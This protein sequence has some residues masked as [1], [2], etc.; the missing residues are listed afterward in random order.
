MLAELDKDGLPLSEAE[1]DAAHAKNFIFAGVMG[2]KHGVADA[3]CEPGPDAMRVMMCAAIPFIRRIA[4]KL[5]Q[6]P[7]GDSAA[8]LEKLWTLPDTRQN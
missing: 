8:F 4:E 7:K 1:V 5:T 6:A 2:V 3:K